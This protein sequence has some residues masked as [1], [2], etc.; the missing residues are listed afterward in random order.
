MADPVRAAPSPAS[1]PADDPNAP[2]ALAWALATAVR[3]LTIVP[4]P[5]GDGAVGRS[6]LFFPLVGLGLGALLAC[7][8]GA[9]T[10]VAPLALR[11][12]LLVALLVTLAGRAPLEGLVRT[13]DALPKHGPAARCARLRA[14]RVGAVGIV[15]VVLVL[16]LA[17][18]SLDAIPD[19]AR[20]LPL[21]LAPM[22]ARWSIVAL[23][24]GSVP[25]AD[26]GRGLA[27]VRTLG[28]REFGVASV[29]AFAVMLGWAEARG[30]LAIVVLAIATIGVR[31]GTHRA[32]GGVTGDVLMAMGAL[33]DALVL[34]VFALGR[35]A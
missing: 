6:A 26:D 9:L 25:A 31:I 10:A 24:F 13:A 28:F 2:R 29:G 1:P 7:A 17:L 11:N 22:L 20:T 27:M 12:L 16:G 34:A 32:F 4:L 14:G 8:D 5:G 15:A 3:T 30:L 23:A 18:R 19:G 35:S 21:L 33:G